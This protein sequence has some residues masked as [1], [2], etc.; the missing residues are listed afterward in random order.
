MKHGAHIRLT[1]ENRKDIDLFCSKNKYIY[2][3]LPLER[4]LEILDKKILTFV[5]PTKWNDPFDNFL[6]K[7][8]EVPQESFLNRL[9]VL[10]FT[11]NSHSQAYW[12]T[13]SPSGFGVR[14]RI[15]S[16]EFIKMLMRNNDKVWLGKM[17]YKYESRLTEQLKNLVGLR[18]SMLL[19]EPNPTFFEA[20]HLKRMPFEYEK[21]SRFSILLSDE[22]KSGLKKINIDPE[23]VFSEI[24]LDP[25][26]GDNE[27]KAWKKHLSQYKIPVKK[28]LLFKDKNITII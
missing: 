21:E 11:H 15:R 9:Y 20:F 17:D 25:K 16:E 10:C 12:N 2:R 26:M 18:D 4:L 7:E 5:S 3:F 28:S 1:E 13:Y 23:S 14:L 27:T 8:Y 6:F 19:D 22:N 24:Y